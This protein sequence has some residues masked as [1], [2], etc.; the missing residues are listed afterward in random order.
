MRLTG[1]KALITGAASGFGKQTA[2]IF[3]REGADVALCDIDMPG[4]QAT[5]DEVAGQGR[6][7]I[8]LRLDVANET[9]VRSVFSQALAEFGRLDI[10]VNSAGVSRS[11]NIQDTSL[12]AWQRTIDVNLTGT[13]LCCREVIPHML[14]NSYGKIIN[15]ASISA[16]TA[17]PVGADYSASKSGVM[18]LTRTLALQVAKDGI[19]VNA[20]APGPVATPLFKDFPPEVVERLMST[21]P[22]KR[23]GTAT[24]IAN[25]I[26]FLAS[27][28]SEWITGEM[29]TINGGAFIG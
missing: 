7:A 22:Y 24:D 17:R 29:V 15:I 10:L 6:K 2:V 21:I 25:L 28:E 9:E 3:A 19:N 27:E 12:Q 1:R 4:L 18:G 23:W 13:F 14:A 20:I 8:R 16:Q 5:A 26:L 11:G